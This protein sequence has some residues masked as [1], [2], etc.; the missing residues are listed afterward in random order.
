MIPPGCG[1]R[2][3]EQSR[4]QVALSG[5]RPIGSLPDRNQVL[6]DTQAGPSHSMVIDGDGMLEKGLFD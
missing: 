2:P 1:I 6:P 5:Q 4:R 3:A